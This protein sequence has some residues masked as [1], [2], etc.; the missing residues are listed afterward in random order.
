[1]AQATK[2]IAFK[3]SEELASKIANAAAEGGQSLSEYVKKTVETQIARR[4]LDEVRKNLTKRAEELGI[5]PDDVM[6]YIHEMRERYN[7]DPEYREEFDREAALNIER[8]R[9][10]T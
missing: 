3:A 2:T 10:R 5:T 9:N 7:S 8:Y 4:D 1:M 6:D